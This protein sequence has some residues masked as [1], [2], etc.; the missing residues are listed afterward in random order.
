MSDLE[1]KKPVVPPELLLTFVLVTILFPLWGFAND[2]TNPMV[3]A[4][5]N[6]L[7]L[8]NFESSMVQ[9][10]FYG[11]YA[12]M[13][14][15]A[16]LFIKKFSYKKGVVIGLALY[17]LA[18]LMFIPSGMAMSYPLF[19]LSYLIMTS[20]L[21]FLETTA[22]PYILSMGDE[23]TA[24]RRLNLAQAFNPMGSIVGM[25]VASMFILASLD[26]TSETA[27]RQME[28]LDQNG[29]PVHLQEVN[30]QIAT[31]DS[32]AEVTG[33]ESW[34]ESKK[35]FKKAGELSAS[36]K[37][38]TFL[39]DNAHATDADSVQEALLAQPKGNKFKAAAEAVAVVLQIRDKPQPTP[40][41]AQRNDFF[42]GDRGLELTLALNKESPLLAKAGAGEWKV[43]EQHFNQAVAPAAA[44]SLMFVPEASLDAAK[45]SAL[46]AT[47][48]QELNAA[49]TALET[50][51]TASL[52][53]Y[54]AGAGS[55]LSTIQKEDLGI[56]S[57]PYALMGGFLI[58]VVI[59][60]AWKLPAKTQ[61]EH[62]DDHGG[63]D[64]G[65]T[66]KR[67]F[68]NPTYIEGVV[69][70]TFYV[71][72]QIMCWTFIVQYGSMEL[73]LSKATAQNCNI[74]AMIIFV[75]S[76]F[77]CT[78][79]MHYI[80]S[81]ALLTILASGAI[82]LTT[83]TIFVDGYAGLYCLIGVSACMSLMFPTIYGIALDGLGDDAKLGSAGLILAIG[84]GCI[85]TPLQGRIIDLP[86]IDLGFRELASVRASFV[87]PLICFMVIALYGWR[88]YSIHHKKEQA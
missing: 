18:C 54:F 41:E 70:Q 48:Q 29:T 8:S 3:A 65:G 74:L 68:K 52:K 24:T 1:K 50:I 43:A 39:L 75:S 58:L 86:A 13:A 57:L 53:E 55:D 35:L 9:A 62:Q 44:L 36:L 32:L 71:G 12:L 40:A 59:L 6:I 16:A 73:G 25:F 47:V 21:S 5:K 30:G 2:I 11:G 67:L 26:G 61:G 4:F 85:M 63:M 10:A 14:I 46:V 28:E 23:S 33:I 19:L 77:V 27:R 83:G 37:D 87:L 51:P 88:T 22:N 60:F 31:V 84:G 45:A 80:S 66:V 56:V 81:G 78:F 42:V 34:Q 64:I 72:A 69:A 15:P 49:K 38:G 79:L 82:L 7:L 20:G 17:S 76:R